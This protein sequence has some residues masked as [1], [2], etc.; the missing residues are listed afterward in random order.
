MRKCCRFSR[1][2]VGASRCFKVLC[3]CFGPYAALKVSLTTPAHSASTMR[4]LDPCDPKR[5][6]PASHP[7]L[8][9][10]PAPASASESSA[11]AS[12]FARMRAG[13]PTLVSPDHL[14]HAI[15]LL[16]TKSLLS[17][18]NPFACCLFCA[19]FSHF[20]TLPLTLLNV[21]AL[22]SDPSFSLYASSR[23]S[24]TPSLIQLPGQPALLS[25]PPAAYSISL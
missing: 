7:R 11:S 2:I 12:E 16:H 1:S 20:Y 10:P 9:S 6:L 4:D 25:D 22:S 18:V 24:D 21:S 8:A 13:L 5:P 14:P 19:T 3:L 23:S 15:T 17:R